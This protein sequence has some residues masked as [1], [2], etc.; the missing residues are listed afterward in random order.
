MPN[1]PR[2]LLGLAR[3][4]AALGNDAEAGEAYSALTQVWSGH[5]S[6]EGM[7]EARRFLRETTR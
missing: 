7:R 1:R 3:A 6:F 2:S 4:N 5:E